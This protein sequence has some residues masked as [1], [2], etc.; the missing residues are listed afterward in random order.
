[1]P[2]LKLPYNVT[3][4]VYRYSR[5]AVSKIGLENP[6]AAAQRFLQTNEISM[7]YIDQVA[8]FIEKNTSGMSLDGGSNEY[9][10]PFTGEPS[11]SL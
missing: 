11:A 9:A 1:M 6:Y 4:A 3:G 7:N 5:C 10:D 8:Q 2:P